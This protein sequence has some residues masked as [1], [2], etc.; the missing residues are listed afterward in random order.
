MT[1]EQKHLHWHLRGIVGSLLLLDSVLHEQQADA[2]E[3][4]DFE[5]PSIG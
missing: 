5:Q 4:F 3:L 1:P 2:T